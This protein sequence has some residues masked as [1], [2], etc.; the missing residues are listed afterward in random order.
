MEAEWDRLRRRWARQHRRAPRL[1][2]PLPRHV[3]LRLAATKVINTTGC[4]LCDHGRTRLAM[5]LWRACGM[6]KL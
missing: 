1:L 6:W 4:W 2:T 3:R 5:L